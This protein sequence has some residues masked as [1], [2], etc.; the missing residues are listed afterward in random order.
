MD[1]TP[2]R[3]DL[4][5]ELVELMELGRPFKGPGRDRALD[6]LPVT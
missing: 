6:Q 5:D 2:L 4:I 3:T 1:V